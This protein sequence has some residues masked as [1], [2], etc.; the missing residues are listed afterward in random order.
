MRRIGV[1]HLG[2]AGDLRRGLRRALRVVAGDQHMDVAAE[3][4]ARR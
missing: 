2:H 4:A 3:L 1:Q